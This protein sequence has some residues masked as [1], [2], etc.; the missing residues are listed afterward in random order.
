MDVD[1]GSYLDTENVVHPGLT[2]L[3][4]STVSLLAGAPPVRPTME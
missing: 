3:P 2:M 1:P 4:L